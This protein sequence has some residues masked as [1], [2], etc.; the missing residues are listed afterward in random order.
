MGEMKP[1]M[2]MDM[3]YYKWLDENRQNPAM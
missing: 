1:G 3:Y 2:I